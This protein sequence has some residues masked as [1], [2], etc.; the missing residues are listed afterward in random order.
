MRRDLIVGILIS[1]ALH[2]GAALL[3]EVFKSGPK[4][5]QHKEETPT[6]QLMEMPKLEPDEPE[7]VETDEP[8]TAQ[9]DLAPPMAADVPQLVT[10]DSFVQ[11]VQPPPPEGLKPSASA[12]T[13]PQ[14][15]PGGWAKGIEVFD[16][17]K[18]DQIPQLKFRVSPQYPFE[19]RRA[20]ITGDVLLD[21]I[22]DSNGEVRNAYAVR[23]TQRE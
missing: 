5:T 3:G 23:S 17:S 1:I 6:V 8:V 16:I 11:Q 20:G 13:I 12:I 4:H 2:G 7:K 19:M 14:G 10:V 9:V 22:V 21:F 15:K 18:L